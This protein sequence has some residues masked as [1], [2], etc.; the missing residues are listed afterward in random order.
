MVH[1]E[2]IIFMHTTQGIMYL[3]KFKKLLLKLFRKQV[4]DVLSEKI[5]SFVSVEQVT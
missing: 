4:F 3:W 2:T 1:F 5:A